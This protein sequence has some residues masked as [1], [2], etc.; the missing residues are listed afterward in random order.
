[1][2]TFEAGLRLALGT[3]VFMMLGS[4]AAWAPGSP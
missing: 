3:I 2:H 4:S 1:M